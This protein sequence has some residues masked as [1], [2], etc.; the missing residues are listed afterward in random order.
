M[1]I[2]NLRNKNPTFTQQKAA[3]ENSNF[4]VQISTIK[5]NTIYHLKNFE[6]IFSTPI[7]IPKSDIKISLK[8]TVYIIIGNSNNREST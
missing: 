3:T 6:I 4:R 8:Q 5:I 1:H 7:K 2:Y